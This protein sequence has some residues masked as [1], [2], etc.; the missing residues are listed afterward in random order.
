[1]TIT[2]DAGAQAPAAGPT[3]RVGQL[4]TAIREQRGEWSTR[5][6]LA[7]YRRRQLGPAG[8]TYT[9]LR[10][11]ARGDLRDLHAWGW[12]L[13][14]HDPNRLYYTLNTQKDQAQ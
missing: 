11:V 13:K 14:S 5:R 8:A 3:G 7:L 1:M 2:T 6:V 10:A 12:L 4:L 9:D